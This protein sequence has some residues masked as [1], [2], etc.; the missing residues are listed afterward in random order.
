MPLCLHYHESHWLPEHALWRPI[1][2]FNQL[3][4][5]KIALTLD[6]LFDH[7]NETCSLPSVT[8]DLLRK[9]QECSCPI[10][11]LLGSR[12]LTL[13]LGKSLASR[14]LLLLSLVMLWSM[15]SSSPVS[16][17]SDELA[18]RSSW[19][20]LVPPSLVPPGV[21]DGPWEELPRIT[22]LTDGYISQTYLIGVI[23]L[24][25]LAAPARDPS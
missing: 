24:L 10:S 18:C 7:D 14:Y 11:L 17:T 9:M 15:S 16:S 23:T 6:N 5:G 20:W 21:P 19:W 2:V 1:L 4:L 25:T 12:L 22:A 13:W 8:G 3:Y